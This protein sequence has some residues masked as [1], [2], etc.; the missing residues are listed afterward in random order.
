M[1]AT[2]AAQEAAE[3]VFFGQVVIIW[4]RWFIIAVGTAVTLAN[5]TSIAAI[6][7]G[8]FFVVVLMLVNF[9]VH[10]RYL[11]ERPV[12]RQLINLLSLLD[13]IVITTIV[14]A[15]PGVRGLESQFFVFYFP[16]VAAFAFVATRIVE[17]IYT[18]LACL[19]YAIGC[20]LVDPTIFGDAIA[21]GF[22]SD[23]GQLKVL[24]LRVAAIAA[25]GFLANFYF[26]ILRAR[27]RA[28]VGGP[29]AIP[30]LTARA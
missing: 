19:L 22:T 1:D 29:S 5:A 7:A 26:R 28:V 17:T 30:D 27:R 3:D 16:V 18:A 2:R 13:L 21:G 12:N 20:A 8:T 15:W 23:V 4:A 14:L 24:I 6:Q 11:I 25:M 9:F 10:A